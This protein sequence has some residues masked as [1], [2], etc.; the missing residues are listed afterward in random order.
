MRNFLAFYVNLFL[1]NG[2]K[3]L[4]EQKIKN[5]ELHSHPS[6]SCVW[7]NVTTDVLTVNLV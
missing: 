7:I 5:N 2:G 3:E 1:L 6:S 4:L